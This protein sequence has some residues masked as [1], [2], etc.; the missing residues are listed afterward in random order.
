MNDN[1]DVKENS[2]YKLDGRLLDIL[3]MDRSYR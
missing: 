2:I 3:L 1:I